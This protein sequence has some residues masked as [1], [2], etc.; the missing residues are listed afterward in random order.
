MDSQ[1]NKIISTTQEC[2]S[3]ESTCGDSGGEGG[4]AECL[5]Q[6]LP[7]TP[8]VAVT[9]GT[10]S[11]TPA[12]TPSQSQHT[13]STTDLDKNTPSIDNLLQQEEGSGSMS[14]IEA[15]GSIRA[16]LLPGETN[17]RASM[18]NLLETSSTAS[19]SIHRNSAIFVED[20]ANLDTG[21]EGCRR[22]EDKELEG[23]STSGGT[24]S[25][26]ES[27]SRDSQSSIR[28]TTGG[29]ISGER[30]E[31]ASEDGVSG[32]GQ[33]VFSEEMP[34]GLDSYV[35]LTG[36]IKRGKKKGQ[37]I[38]VKVNLSREELDDLE[39]SI[40]QTMGP[41]KPKI[42]CS[43]RY[44]AHI[45]FL[46]LLCMPIAFLVSAAYS[47]YL[48][49]LTWYSILTRVTEAR[50]AAKM[51]LPPLLI[52]LYPFLILLFTLGLGI[53]GALSQVSLSYDTWYSEMSDPEKGFYGWLCALL[54][55]E[56]C[57]PYETV[58]LMTDPQSEPPLPTKVNDATV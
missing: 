58:V 52:L 30:G 15:I 5:L 13:A 50:W 2:E 42:C 10:P 35:T 19:D 3:A 31:G 4:S 39:A 25:S 43:Q 6:D 20:T 40:T 12:M 23:L 22:S 16:R 18:N 44:G 26:I 11:L 8:G 48:G 29:S 46:S 1:V 55:V 9:P 33:V 51:T 36:T 57:A 47:F 54:Q 17:S 14:S 45:T 37:S 53:F 41:D 56:E 21:S 34:E 24:K 7:P 49:T 28:P 32:G 27:E 38:D